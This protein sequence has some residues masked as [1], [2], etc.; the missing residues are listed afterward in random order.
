LSKQI[1]QETAINRSSMPEELIE[2]INRGQGL[3]RPATAVA[4]KK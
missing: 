4:G 2:M 1:T 3:N